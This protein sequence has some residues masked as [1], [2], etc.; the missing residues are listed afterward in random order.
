M[1]IPSALSQPGFRR[2][3]RI[4]TA[5]LALYMVYALVPLGYLV[6]SATKS[7]K[8][9]FSTFGL[10]FGDSNNLW[11][12]LI[13][14]FAFNDG[15]YLRW[16]ANSLGYSLAAACGATLICACAGYAFAKFMFAG[17]SGLNRVL[18]L[19]MAIPQTVFVIPIF[20]MLSNVGIVNTP[21]A[22]ILPS[23]AFLPGVYMLRIY[24]EEAIPDELLDAARIDGA[25]EFRIFG[26]IAF[27]IMVPG[28]LTVF[29]HTFVNTWNNYLL[30]LVVLNSS[31]NYPVALGLA[32]MYTTTL[33]GGITTPLYAVILTGCLV[34]L[35]PI[36]L[37]FL[38]MQRYWQSGLTAGGLK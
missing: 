7:D 24:A 23:L 29:L 18:L 33:S 9:I 4:N 30:P 28:M 15:I 19:S 22:V 35:L 10:W 1:T 32:N 37:L 17:R 21:L 27:P 6:V 3:R 25:G 31:E 38:I 36:V 13:S 34:S 11:A 14:L 5:L 2:T 16:L 26:T 12:N 20:L 8:Q